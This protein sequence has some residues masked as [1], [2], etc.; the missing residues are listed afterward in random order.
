MSSSTERSFGSRIE[1]AKKL[2]TFITGFQNFQPASGEFSID[3][4]QDAITKAETLNPQV[5]TALFNYRQVV[6]QRRDIYIKSPLSI[7]RIL[8][9]VNSYHR[10]KFGKN[11]SN[12]NAIRYLVNKIRG[13]RLKSEVKADAET[14]SVSQQSYG[15]ILLNFQNL[16]NDIEA[17]GTQYNPANPEIKLGNLISLKTQAETSNENATLAFGILTPKQDQRFD[18][19]NALSAKAQRI[20]DYVQSQYGIYSSEYKLVRGLNI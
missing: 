16:I 6:A 7:K 12:Y 14:H 10:A 5:A 18:A 2:K 13:E 11:S 4:L 15:S 9:P 1:K 8:T 19:F 17:L 3:D 20:K